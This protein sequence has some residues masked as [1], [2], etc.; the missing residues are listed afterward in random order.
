MTKT[1]LHDRSELKLVFSDEF[2]NDNRTFY[3]GDDPYWEAVD[4]HY[5][6]TDDLKWYDPTTI[7]TKDGVLKITLSKKETHDL[8]HQGSMM[9]SRNQF[10]FT[11]GYFDIVWTK[12]GRWIVACCLGNGEPRKGRVWCQLGGN[13]A[14]PDLP[15]QNP[16]WA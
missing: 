2:N 7:T 8:N 10:C 15:K 11:G 3:P 4:L 14:S 16:V 5:W 9:T 13:G 6:Q 1:S 12:R